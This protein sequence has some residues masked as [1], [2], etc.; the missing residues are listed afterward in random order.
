MDRNKDR[1]DNDRCGT[2]CD[3]CLIVSNM[4]NQGPRMLQYRSM[5]NASVGSVIGGHN[6]TGLVAES[7]GGRIVA[8]I[9]YTT[10]TG[11][12]TFFSAPS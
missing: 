9:S 7:V 12:L 5:K 4:S 3:Q 1:L 8:F 10:T 2:A 11:Q 6:G